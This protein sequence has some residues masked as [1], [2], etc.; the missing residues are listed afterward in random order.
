MKLV[1]VESGW[2]KLDWLKLDLI[3]LNWI[4]LDQ[5]IETWGWGLVPHPYLILCLILIIEKLGLSL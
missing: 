4:K 1:Q 2:I 5:I 3:G